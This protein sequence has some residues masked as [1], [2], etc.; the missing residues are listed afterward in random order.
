MNDSFPQFLIPTSSQQYDQIHSDQVFIELDHQR[1]I[2][3]MPGRKPYDH[4]IFFGLHS[5]NQQGQISTDQYS[6]LFVQLKCSNCIQVKSK[7]FDQENE[8]ITL[9]HFKHQ[10]LRLKTSLDDAEST[11]AEKLI[12]QFDTERFLSLQLING[13]EIKIIS[14]C[15]PEQKKDSANQFA[16]LNLRPGACNTLFLSVYLNF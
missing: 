6:A 7:L 12:V 11:N 5:Y 14:Y 15:G 10:S 16:M 13:E 1:K 9:P 3:L 2:I 4:E 8:E